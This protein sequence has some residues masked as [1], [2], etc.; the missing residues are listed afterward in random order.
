MTQ[1][2]SIR[3][4]TVV[5]AGELTMSVR[6]PCQRE[7]ATSTYQIREWPLIVNSEG[8]DCA[9]KQRRRSVVQ[10]YRF[11]SLLVLLVL[12]QA[13]Q[14]PETTVLQPH[15]GQR[16][17]PM[18]AN[19]DSG[20]SVPVRILCDRHTTQWGAS[21]YAPKHPATQQQLKCPVVRFRI[22]RSFQNAT[23]ERRTLFTIMISCKN[24]GP[25]KGYFGVQRETALQS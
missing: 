15:S 13:A 16:G 12:Y 4:G 10:K 25:I 7:M 23:W 24:T 17:Q 1:F 14:P 3:V 19:Q 8:K 6:Y 21:T 18:M 2:T 20:P 9:M 5:S 11:T 22:T